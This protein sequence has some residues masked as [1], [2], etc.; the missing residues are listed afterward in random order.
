MA[1]AASLTFTGCEKSDTASDAGRY[2]FYSMTE[3]GGTITMQ[4][5]EKMYNEMDMEAPEMYLELNEDGTG[6]LIMDDED[7]QKVEWK[8]GVITVDGED[9]KYTI[10][11]GKLTLEEGDTTI[12]FEKAK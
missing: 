10:K 4:E 7:N 9:S 11:D 1:I 8:E 2:N 3:D 6:Q 5:L 12:V